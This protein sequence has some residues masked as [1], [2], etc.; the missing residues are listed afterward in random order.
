MVESKQ[1]ERSV[2]SFPEETIFTIGDLN[3][4]TY[5]WDNIRVK[6]GRMVNEGSLR[7]AGK[8]RFYRPK[9]T[10][11][12]EV[13]PSQ[14]EIVKD[15]LWDGDTPTG[16]ITGYTRWN[17]MGLTSQISGI[18]QIGING[19]KRNL[20]RGEYSVR[21]IKQP[22]EITVDNIRYLI[23]LDAIN[24]IRKIP[25]TTIVASVDRLIEII[26]RLRPDEIGKMTELSMKY[27]AR[28][29]ALLGA[30]FEKIGHESPSSQLY[31]TLNPLTSYDYPGLP[32]HLPN[33][34]KWH[35]NETSRR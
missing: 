6:L 28:L 9:I 18:I 25:D 32:E 4:P 1:I 7:K 2:L 17:Q 20:A 13:M 29:R 26:K 22:N 5:S 34:L 21:F 16:Y 12:G 33:S 27:P 8:G 19:V 23:I 31:E 11:F 14:E 15:L 30:M 10:I 35:I 3:L 24:N